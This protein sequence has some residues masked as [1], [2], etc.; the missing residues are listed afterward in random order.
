MGKVARKAGVLRAQGMRDG[1]PAVVIGVGGVA[2][3]RIASHWCRCWLIP[4]CAHEP[5]NPGGM[6]EIDKPN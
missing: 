3:S 2:R 4:I 6:R 1:N 5:K